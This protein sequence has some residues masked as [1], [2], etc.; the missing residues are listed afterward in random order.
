[1]SRLREGEG[2]DKAGVTICTYALVEISRRS[3]KLEFDELISLLLQL[4]NIRHVHGLN[5][6]VTCS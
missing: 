4:L 6:I 5:S 3:F 1:M 2:G